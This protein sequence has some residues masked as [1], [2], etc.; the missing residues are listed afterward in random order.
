M[1]IFCHLL[2]DN[3]GSPIVLKATLEALNAPETGQLFVGSQGAGVLDHIN[4][5][6]RNY[7]YRHSRHRIITL[8]N[9][10]LSQIL[11]YFSLS[12]SKL[13]YDDTVIF[14]NTLLPIGA[15]IW[16]RR[17]KIPLIVH[18]HEISITPKPFRNLLLRCVKYCADLLL[19]VSHDHLSRLPI[20]GVPSKVLHNPV[21]PAI[22]ERSATHVRTSRDKFTVLMLA[23]PRSYKGLAEFINL[24]NALKSRDDIRFHLVLNANLDE[25]EVFKEKHALI[26]NLT[27]FPQ[28]DEPANFY[29]NADLLLNLS[30]VDQWIETFG[31]TLVEAMSF[32]M[33][34]IGPPVGGPAEII[35][36]GKDGFCIDSRDTE[37]LLQAVVKL[38]DNKE[39]YAAMSMAA[40][41]RARSFSFASYSA[42]LNSIMDDFLSNFRA[43]K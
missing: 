43:Q 36:H 28:T 40:R 14:V 34:V 8:F 11:L 39:F 35:T 19:Y 6:K 3:S 42:K 10:L 1:I 27:I 38:V 41:A 23:S 17:N 4:L 9:Y 26:S 37:A 20:E 13:N 16:A 33:P 22:T 29:E 32:G 5:P 24:A 30:R 7:F 18:V 15:M 21:S 31:L 25:T 12:R 2:N